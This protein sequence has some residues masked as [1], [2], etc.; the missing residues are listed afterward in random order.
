[1]N[2]PC[3]YLLCGIFY[4]MMGREG[5]TCWIAQGGTFEFTLKRNGR[6]GFVGSVDVISRIL[7][8]ILESIRGPWEKRRRRRLSIYHFVHLTLIR[9]ISLVYLSSLASNPR[10]TFNLV[11]DYITLILLERLWSN[12]AGTKET[13]RG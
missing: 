13:G 10:L 8:E 3:Q 6:G 5:F 11:M 2:G 7:L 4:N 12:P 1:M 9:L